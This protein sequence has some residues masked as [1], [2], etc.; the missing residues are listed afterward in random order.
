MDPEDIPLGYYTHIFFSFAYID[1]EN[2]RI[3]EMDEE[4]ARR[5]GRVTALKEYDPEL[6]VWISIGGWA[7]NNEGRWRNAFS[8]MAKSEENQDEFF[9]SLVSLLKQYG[10]D[11][12]DLD[13][14]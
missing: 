14:E 12:V 2:F 6:E 11:G 7:M 10:F 13:W 1:P 3:D 4:T 5:Y 8:D 9:D